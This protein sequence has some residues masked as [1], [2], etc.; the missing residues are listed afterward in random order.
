M[1]G[2]AGKPCGDPPEHATQWF[3]EMVQSP[4]QYTG[5]NL[6]D[7]NGGLPTSGT[8]KLLDESASHARLAGLGFF[9]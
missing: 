1:K 8:T 3:H 6:P 2:W 7:G 9:E 4:Q 5:S